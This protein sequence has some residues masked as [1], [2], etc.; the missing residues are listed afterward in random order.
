M[1]QAV[2]NRWQRLHRI[3]GARQESQG[4]DDEVGDRRHLV[5]LGGKY[6]GEQAQCAHEGPALYH[7]DKRD[8]RG[9][10]G[11]RPHCHKPQGFT[12][13][14]R[15]E[16]HPIHRPKAARA[17]IHEILHDLPHT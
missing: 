11:L 10:Q 16:A 7:K 2:Q 5:E 13:R 3:E 9:Q 15:I 17:L 1:A 4:R 6:S 8:Q 14:Q 12:L